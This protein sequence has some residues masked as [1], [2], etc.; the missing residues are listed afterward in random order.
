MSWKCVPVAT[1]QSLVSRQICHCCHHRAFCDWKIVTTRAESW[2]VCY[3]WHASLFARAKPSQF[4]ISFQLVHKT[5]KGPYRITHIRVILFLINSFPFC[6][7]FLFLVLFPLFCLHLPVLAFPSFFNLFSIDLA[8]LFVLLPSSSLSSLYQSVGC[9]FVLLFG[10]KSDSLRDWMCV[11]LACCIW[12]AIHS[13]GTLEF[14]LKQD[15]CWQTS[16]PFSCK[17]FPPLH[18]SIADGQRAHATL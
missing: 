8:L 12:K 9:A 11:A 13:A 17:M 3:Q 18:T 6:F 10:I 2:A 15:W 4:F 16:H 7:L 14:N 5:L 1:P